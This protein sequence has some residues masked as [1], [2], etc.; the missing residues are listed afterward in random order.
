M[1][2]MIDVVLAAESSAVNAWAMRTELGAALV[3]AAERRRSARDL[4]CKRLAISNLAEEVCA[5][6]SH[7]I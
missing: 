6:V 5:R 3:T 1:P 2:T 4:F 7:N